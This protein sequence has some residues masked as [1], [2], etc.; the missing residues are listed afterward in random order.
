MPPVDVVLPCLD[1]ARALPVVLAGLPD[2]V[3]AIVID[4]GSTDGSDRIAADLGATVVRCA[5]RGYGAAC[6]AGLEAASAEIVAFCDCDGSLDLA[7]V[8]RFEAVLRAG[9][10][11][12]VARRRPVGRDAMS[13]SSR[14]ANRELARRI[15]KRTGA[16]IQDVGPL[17][18]ARRVPLL[19]LGLTDRRSGYPA[20]TV[21]RAADAGWTITQLDVEYRPRIG[22]SKVTGTL[23]GTLRAVRDMSAAINRDGSTS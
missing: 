10:D 23:R 20:E 4:N 11:L 17:R 6:H 19:E 2:G 7:D 3:R 5:V 13:L 22:Q 18:A 14:V 1:E 12:V 16:R 15:R 8:L 21:V 9:S